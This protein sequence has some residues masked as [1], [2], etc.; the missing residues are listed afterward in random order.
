VLLEVPAIVVKR[1]PSQQARTPKP[2][3]SANNDRKPVIVTAKRRSSDS[4]TVST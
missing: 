3:A 2:V 4:A 1:A